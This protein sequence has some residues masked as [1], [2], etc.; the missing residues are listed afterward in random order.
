M[1][2]G[3]DGNE[4]NVREKVGVSVYTLRLLQYFQK[5][6]SK[7][8][9]FVVFL[10][11]APL[12]ELPDG[13]DFYS[14]K[15]IRSSFLWSQLFLPFELF[16]RIFTHPIDVFFSPAHYAPRF[17]PCPT[18]VTIHD[19]AYVHY[20]D[21]FLKRDLFQLT[22]WTRYSI[23]NASK[24]IS[25][26][27]TTK[28]DVIAQYNTTE[29]KIEVIYNGFEKNITSKARSLSSLSKQYHFN[30]PYI[31]YVGTL[32]P[33]K[34]IITLIKSFAF[35]NK[36]HPEYSLVIV[37]KKGWLFDEI[38]KEAR[39][40][41]VNNKIIFTG[42]VT[43]DELAVLYKNSHCFVLP[44]FY[45]GFGLPLLEA[46]SF[47]TPVISSFASS[48]PEI[49]G[50]A[51]LYFDP[52]DPTDLFDKLELLTYDPSLQKQLIAEGK[53]RTLT[54][55]WNKCAKETLAVLMSQVKRR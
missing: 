26:S 20:P 6:A 23:K 49:G 15:I 18:V 13:T 43:D 45:E 48:L 32:Q 33:R 19:V 17:C 21:E 4:A 3:V 41:Y 31:L 29:N 39:D 24:I 37:G 50:E 8:L 14:Y 34:N 46:M 16:K 30:T 7:N 2:I 11:S 38:F 27:K 47:G 9:Q 12:K 52:Q 35:F 5:H 55:S 44:S 25:V 22:H 36:K 53:K 40:Q 51:C 1:L 10:R 28:K 54:Y 42:Y